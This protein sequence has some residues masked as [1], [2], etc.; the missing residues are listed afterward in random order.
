MIQIHILEVLTSASRIFIK[1][2]KN[3]L[4][5]L[6]WG[7]KKTNIIV[8]DFLPLCEHVDYQVRGKA[9]IFLASVASMSIRE[10]VQLSYEFNESFVRVVFDT[11]LD[12]QLVM[13]IRCLPIVRDINTLLDYLISLFQSEKNMMCLKLLCEA[14]IEILPFKKSLLIMFVRMKSSYWGLTCE[15]LNIYSQFYQL[16]E[17][18]LFNEMMNR[19]WS[20]L[21][22]TNEKVR[23]RAIQI[24]VKF[25]VL[26][27]CIE[28]LNTMSS[29]KYQLLGIIELLNHLAKK[30]GSFDD[31]YVYLINYNKS[32]KSLKHNSIEIIHKLLDIVQY[33]I[34]SSD[35]TFLAIVIEVILFNLYLIKKRQ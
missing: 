12:D 3:G 18:S 24:L 17:S 16:M 28:R 5:G 20:S 31:N 21:E 7:K 25:N 19:V 10:N 11:S 8:Q 22:D 15:L 14:F 1:S 23:N 13:N 27:E 6:N 33:S 35:I 2:M 34:F 4:N 26:D 29:N 32:D 30:C 9:A